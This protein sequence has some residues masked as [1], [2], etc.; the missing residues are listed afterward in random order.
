MSESK[1]TV[2]IGAS[3]N[4]SRY[5]YLAA[6][7]LTDYNHE[8]VPVGIKKGEVFGKNILDINSKPDV[9]NVDT[10]TLYIG[11]QHQRE[12]YDY[13]LSLKPRRVIFNPGTENP[14]LEE[15]VE[16]SGAEAIEACTLVM[17]RTGQY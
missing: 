8:F 1:K 2:I 4:P 15:L 9:Q 13:I 7:M 12:H 11:P 6:A 10:V 3:N 14:E 16:A 5:A 17:L